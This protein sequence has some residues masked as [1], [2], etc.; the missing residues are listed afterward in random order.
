M[1]K[2]QY[3]IIGVVIV[4]ILVVGLLFFFNHQSS[5]KQE[6]NNLENVLVIVNDEYIYN[7][8]I[9]RVY[10]QY[11]DVSDITKEKIIEDSINEILVIQTGKKD[12]NINVSDKEI[13]TIIEE[14]KHDFSKQYEKAIE[15]YGE[16]DFFIGQKN[17]LLYSK[18]KEYVLKNELKIDE[19]ISKEQIKQ[20]TDY[21]G[22]TDKL[23]A[24]APEDIVNTF[25]ND[26]ENFIFNQW[27]DSLRKRAEIT[28]L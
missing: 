10:Q 18:T 20:F 25:R 14:Y 26:I 6:P 1:K 16:D 7:Y 27:V 4:I 11:N 28:Y 3:I 12:Y 2:K 21:Y 13:N 9:E 24:Y 15:I 22:I 19:N 17:R 23:S 8:E 5:Q